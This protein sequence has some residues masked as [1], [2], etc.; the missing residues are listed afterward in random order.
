MRKV[1]LVD[2]EVFIAQ[3][4]EVLIDW[5]AE[6]YEIAAV[7]RNGREALDW[8]RG[9]HV[10]LVI[11]DVM[12]PEM[13]GLE[14][15]ETVKREKVSEA[16]FVILSGYGEFAFA[17]QALRYG[18]MD[19]L[20][21]PIERDDLLAILRRSSYASQTAQMEQ[22]YEEAYLARNLVALLHGSRQADMDY[23]RSHMRLSSGVRYLEID[24]LLERDS[25]EEEDA[26]ELAGLRTRIRQSCRQL[27]QGDGDHCVVELSTEQ[28]TCSVGFV[29]CDYMAQERGLTEVLFVQQLHRHLAVSAQRELRIIA[30]E[31]VEDLEQI[32]RSYRSAKDLKT[33][34]AF[35]GQKS[36]YWYEQ[37]LEER[38]KGSMLLRQQ[39]DRLVE[40]VEQGEHGAIER[41]VDEL[42]A[43]MRERN[44][45]SR[46]VNL[47]FHYLLFRLIDLACSLDGDADQEEI[48]QLIS[49]S[50][51]EQGFHR[52]SRRHLTR[53]ACDYADYL[54][55]LRHSEP[56]GI[57]RD[58]EREIRENYAENLTLQDLG[59]KYFINSS[60]LGQ[61]FRKASGQ[62]FKA[63]LTLQRINEASRLLRQTDRKIGDIAEAVGYRDV[64]Y[65]ISRFIELK[66]C[67]PSRYRKNG[68][69]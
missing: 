64:D 66:G 45:K 47:N 33:L 20:L 55:Q 53:F 8:L 43:W 59:R 62:S 36:V 29:C 5:R 26:D 42:F 44:M 30:G 35:R 57:L 15:L 52:G 51:V 48:L 38:E 63:A 11:A 67:T 61:I 9:H 12:M 69:Q 39:L 10:D 54:A 65:F 46:D 25:D 37:E 50:T 14:L 28:L 27:L 60:Y 1:L 6:G 13:T 31:K 32:D 21:K 17:Q 7:C 2:D 3:G 40:A 58:I 23:I 4:L 18:C 49:A 22:K 34:L 41:C 24:V 16:S 56:S 68:K 19:Y